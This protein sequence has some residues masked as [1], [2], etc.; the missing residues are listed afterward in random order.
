MNGKQ[1]RSNL[2]LVTAATIWGFAFVAQSVGM[3]HIGPFTFNA[4]RTLV[5]ALTLLAFLP[6]LDRLNAGAVK[7][8]QTPCERTQLLAAG[9][10]C[11]VL[12]AVASSLQQVGL[13]YTSVGKAGFITAL[14]IILVP[15]L[16]IFIK[17]RVTALIWAAVALATVG[18]YFL[19][20]GTESF[21]IG[22][23]DILVF[24]SAIGFAIHILV[25]DRYSPYV[26][27]V[28][29]SCLQF[30]VCGTVCLVPMFL[31]EHPT[32]AGIMAAGIPILYAG[33]M[34]RG[35]ADTLQILGQKNNNATVASLLMSLESVVS[36]IAGWLILR[37]VLTLRELAG[38]A[39]VFCGI[40]LA[41]LPKRKE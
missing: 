5:G 23:G 29:L 36:V 9:F 15:V 3:N 20:V 19:C 27:C 8:P 4:V 10:Y 13:Q 1:L 11:G 22:M 40:V 18:M 2:M 34:S 35:V 37:Q 30:L 32:I 16:G 28:R 6:L 24:F 41:Q 33:V 14:Y 38:C 7:K 21:S 12:Q 31:F 39:L 26:D 25:V 17:K